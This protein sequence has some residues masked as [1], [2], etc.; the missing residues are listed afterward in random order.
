M[1]KVLWFVLGFALVLIVGGAFLLGCLPNP[2][3]SDATPPPAISTPEATP[4]SAPTTA[5]ALASLAWRRDG[6][7]GC[8]GLRVDD[9]SQLHLVPCEGDAALMRFSQEELHTYLG[10]V[11]R[12]APFAFQEDPSPE[13]DMSTVT[14]TFVGRGTREATIEEQAEMADWAAAVH[15]RIQAEAQ[16]NTMIATARAALAERL[17]IVP[18]VITTVAVES[19]TWPDAC[20][21]LP[22]TGSACAEVETPGY[23]IILRVGND[24]YTYHTDLDGLVRLGVSQEPSPTPTQTVATTPTPTASPTTTPSPTATATATASPTATPVPTWTPAPAPTDHWRAEYYA[25]HQLLG[26]PA[27][28]ARENSVNHTWGYGAPSGVPEDHFSARWTRRI[29]FEDGQYDFRLE[30]DD[31]VRLWVGGM[32]IIDRWSGGHRVDFVSQKHIPAGEHDVV[33]EYFELEGYAKIDLGWNKIYIPPTPAPEPIITDWR[34]EYYNNTTLEGPPALITNEVD[35]QFEW[36]EG[37]PHPAIQRDRFSAR[38]A[39]RLHFSRGEYRLTA[40]VDDGV[41]V[42]IDGRLVIDAW[43]T[44]IR[45]AYTHVLTLDGSH[46]L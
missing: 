32:L 28:V 4:A 20:L 14:L 27:V 41:R 12:Y 21:G 40:V 37:S 26:I 8:S 24:T 33:V 16:R 43:Q 39:R 38:Y 19:V 5:P 36:G 2:Q 25:N 1:K 13:N 11:A 15:A 7:A 9:L 45:R 42:W 31:G 29:H 34:G 22:E 10:Y 44:G 17:N 23:R 46:D 30:A 18:D 3:A 6:A 35:L